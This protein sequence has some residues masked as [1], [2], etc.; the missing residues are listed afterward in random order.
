MRMSEALKL[1]PDRAAVVAQHEKI[2]ENGLPLYAT[3]RSGKPLPQLETLRHLI[4]SNFIVTGG[5][6]CIVT[7]H[8]RAV[9]GFNEELAFGEDW[10]FWCRLA[11]RADFAVLPDLVAVK[12]RLRGDGANARRRGTPRRP[13]FS[14]IDAVY[15]IQGLS[16]RFS[17]E[18]RARA[19]RSAEVDA[20][21][22]SA[23]H[24]LASRHFGTFVRY[25]LVGFWRYPDALL[26][27]A[28]VRRYLRSSIHMVIAR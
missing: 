14:A 6:I 23:R 28:R 15:S 27:P 2:L 21:W 8:A 19:R 13:N 17:A 5:A 10:E 7:A 11:L 12:Y 16:E 1:Q 22:G 26:K 9:G 18:E 24:E 20:F 3:P 25:L 4:E